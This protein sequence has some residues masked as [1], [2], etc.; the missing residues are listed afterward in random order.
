MTRPDIWVTVE[1]HRVLTRLLDEALQEGRLGAATWLANE[2]S[3]ARVVPAQAVPPDC[4]TLHASGR[5]VDLRGRAVR[6]GTL[7]PTRGRSSRGVVPVL[8]E[9]G[10]A[11]LGLR[12]GQSIHWRDAHGR[13]R[14][15]GLLELTHQPERAGGRQ[16][17]SR[18]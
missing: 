17:D 18:T 3:R 16:P 8:S 1:D 9:I 6:E 5:F 7:V 2:L 15:V 14:G 12:A 10:T 4:M 13:Q 11:L